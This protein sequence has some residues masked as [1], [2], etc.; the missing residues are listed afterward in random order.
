MQSCEPSFFLNADVVWIENAATT[1]S[2]AANDTATIGEVCARFGI[3]PRALRFYEAKGLISPQR[4][5]RARIYDSSDCDRL[6]LILKAKKLSF[7]LTEIL[8]MFKAQE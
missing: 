3:T 1:A 5:D 8:E 2:S 7:T 6:A 4:A